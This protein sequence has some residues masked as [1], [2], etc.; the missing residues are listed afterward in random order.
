MTPPDGSANRFLPAERP[1]PLIDDSPVD[2]RGELRLHEFSYRVGLLLGAGLFFHAALGFPWER[3]LFGVTGM[4]LAAL[5]TVT[6]VFSWRVFDDWRRRTHQIV[7][8][9]FFFALSFPLAAAIEPELGSSLLPG[10]VET[11]LEDAF[12]ILK[13]VP[14]LGLAVRFTLGFLSFLLIAMLLLTLALSRR[15]GLSIVAFLTAGLTLFFYP[16]AECLAGF[17]FL[18]LFVYT[19]WEMPVLVPDKLRPHLSPVQWEY[20]RELTRRGM[21]STGET[22]IYLENQ[23][24]NF[25]L[26]ADCHLVEY[27]P[28]SRAIYPGRTLLHDPAAAPVEKT[29]SV[30]RRLLWFGVG[31]LYLLLPDLIPGPV[32]DVI[33]LLLCTMSGTDL[34]RL[35]GRG[36]RRVSPVA[37][38]R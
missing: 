35:A 16:T 28:Y 20:L 12:A 8:L 9:G 4:A 15:A 24:K 5:M 6:L 2:E 32:D 33:I 29:F 23:P 21:L 14:G 11:A 17:L 22:K 13:A 18:A 31:L 36:R 25:A 38:N 30:T 26:L 37:P 1:V 3:G 7:Y 10:F 34:L 27:D 19:Q